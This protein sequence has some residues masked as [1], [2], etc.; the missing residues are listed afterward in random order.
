MKGE[1]SPLHK[2]LL[3]G[4]LYRNCERFLKHYCM[5]LHHTMYMRVKQEEQRTL[6]HMVC[7]MKNTEKMI[8]LGRGGRE[9][10]SDS[11]LQHTQ[12][13]TIYRYLS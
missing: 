9:T 8:P 1:P 11:N 10:R 13:E 2:T 4:N 7:K 12:K 3:E 5:C 6:E